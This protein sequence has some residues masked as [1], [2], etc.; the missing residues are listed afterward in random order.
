MDKKTRW[1]IFGFVI[2]VSVYPAM[3]VFQRIR[4]IAQRRACASNLK[5]LGEAMTVYA[6]DYDGEY[7]V[8]G[9]H[10]PN[11]MTVGESL[12]LLVRE[13][14]VDPNSVISYEE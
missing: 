5:K 3:R 10:D 13:A 4:I 11:Y 12:Y 9:T 14:D 7:F 8:T 1:F 6:N 2:I